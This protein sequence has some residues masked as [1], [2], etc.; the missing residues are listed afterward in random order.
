MYPNQPPNSNTF[1]YEDEDHLLFSEGENS[2]SDY[3]NLPSPSPE[4]QDQNSNSESD[5]DNNELTPQTSDDNNEPSPSP[6]TWPAQDH[7]A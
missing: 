5:D 2:E 6:P 1:A 7:M 3:G 4:H